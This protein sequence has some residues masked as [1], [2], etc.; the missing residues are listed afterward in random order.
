MKVGCLVA[1]MIGGADSIE[2]MDLLRHGAMGALARRLTPSQP[3]AARTGPT[4]SKDLLPL[5]AERHM[6]ASGVWG[7]SNQIGADAWACAPGMRR[8]RRA[9]LRSS[10]AEGTTGYHSARIGLRA[11]RVAIRVETTDHWP[12]PHP[13][14]APGSYTCN[15]QVGACGRPA[16]MPWS[17]AVE[18]GREKL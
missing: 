5:T 4:G 18:S 1:G 13:A 12:D 7:S 6:H 11:P 8:C 17:G 3:P 2:D 15:A 16:Q 9:G 14:L 10:R